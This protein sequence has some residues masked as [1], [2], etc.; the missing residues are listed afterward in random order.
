VCSSL[1]YLSLFRD[2][3]SRRER[4]LRVLAYCL[5]TFGVCVMVTCLVLNI[6]AVVGAS[7]DSGRAGRGGTDTPPRTK[8]AMESF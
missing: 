4:V 1:F 6:Y 7:S 5:L 2:E 3:K 8:L